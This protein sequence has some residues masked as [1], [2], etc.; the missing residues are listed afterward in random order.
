MLE[1]ER[2]SRAKRRRAAALAAGGRPRTATCDGENQARAPAAFV[3]M[4]GQKRAAS[5]SQSAEALLEQAL[6]AV[7]TSNEADQPWARRVEVPTHLTI[8][9]ATV[10][11]LPQ[12]VELEAFWRNEG[13]GSD[14]ATLRQRLEQHPKGQLVAAASDGQLLGVMYSQRVASYKK[15]LSTTRATELALHKPA[16]PVIQLLA[17]LQRPEAKHVGDLLRR[18][19]LQYGRLDPSAER[20]C[21]ITHAVAITTRPAAAPRRHRTARTWTRAATTACSSTRRRGGPSMI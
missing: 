2:C 19:M 3:H 12:L 7:A 20:A 1:N 13:L 14:E 10:F 18:T 15:L 5:V 9:F 6:K 4:S 16:G 21:G 11:D 8:R 17:V